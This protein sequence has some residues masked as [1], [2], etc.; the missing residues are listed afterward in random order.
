MVVRT[1]GKLLLRNPWDFLQTFLIPKIWTKVTLNEVIVPQLLRLFVASNLKLRTTRADDDWI[2]PRIKDELQTGERDQELEIKTTLD[3]PKQ[4][5]FLN[6]ESQPKVKNYRAWAG[7]GAQTYE[8]TN[9]GRA[10]G[11]RSTTA[12]ALPNS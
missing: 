2:Q 9:K 3:D 8:Q 5:K 4:P 11:Q 7:S 1:L 6:A 12:Q 10:G